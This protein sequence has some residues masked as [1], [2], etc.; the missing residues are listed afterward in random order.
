M[1][2]LSSASTLIWFIAETEAVGFSAVRR[3]IIALI[4]F[5]NDGSLLATTCDDAVL[6]WQLYGFPCGENQN[7]S[8]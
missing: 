5:G 8:S 1:S 4:H 3:L 6:C 2:T 7:G